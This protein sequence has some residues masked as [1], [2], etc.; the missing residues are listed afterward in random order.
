MNLKLGSRRNCLI[1][2]VCRYKPLIVLLAAAGVSIWSIFLL[3]DS[4]LSLQIVEIIYGTY[5]A[6]EVAYFSYIY[7]K[8]D[9]QNYQVVTSHT[10]A[11]MFVG[12]FVAATSSQLLVFFQIMDYRQ[13]NFLTLSSSLPFDLIYALAIETAF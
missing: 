6:C 12:R 11:A 1:E 9:K 5:C 4:V 8:T 3:A 7:A 13:L 10:R 2:I